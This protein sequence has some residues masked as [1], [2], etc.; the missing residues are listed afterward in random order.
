MDVIVQSEYG[1]ARFLYERLL[2]FVNRIAAQ[3][4]TFIHV[5]VKRR[6]MCDDEIDA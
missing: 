2:L 4:F 3:P 6:F 1:N 5:V